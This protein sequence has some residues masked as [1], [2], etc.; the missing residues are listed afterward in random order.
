MLC[1]SLVGFKGKMPGNLDPHSQLV[2]RHL[3]RRHWVDVPSREAYFEVRAKLRKSGSTEYTDADPSTRLA[4]PESLERWHEE[5][6]RFVF[7]LGSY[8]E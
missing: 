1:R 5:D 3:R 8:Q 2:G 7:L 4:V 6:K